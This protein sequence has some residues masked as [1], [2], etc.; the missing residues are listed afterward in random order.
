[1]CTCIPLKSERIKEIS[2][3]N[4]N[5]NQL[6]ITANEQQLYNNFN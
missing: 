1:M 5:Q 6:I 3:V 2:S 4:I